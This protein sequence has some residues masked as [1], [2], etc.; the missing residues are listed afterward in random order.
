MDGKGLRE[1]DKMDIF[2]MLSIGVDV[3]TVASSLGITV[4]A[5]RNVY[6]ET[7]DDRQG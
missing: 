4:H 3:K 2:I 7:S 6:K 1:R 5:T